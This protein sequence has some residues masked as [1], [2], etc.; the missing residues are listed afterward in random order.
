VDFY[1]AR[2]PEIAPLLTGDDVGELKPRRMVAIQVR[3]HKETSRT[4]HDVR[5]YAVR[6]FRLDLFFGVF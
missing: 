1:A 3:R 4:L 5:I 2:W 6:N